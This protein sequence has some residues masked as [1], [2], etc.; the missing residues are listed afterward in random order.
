[1]LSTNSLELICI[2]RRFHPT[3]TEGTFFFQ[4][5]GKAQTVRTDK[6]ILSKKNKVGGN[7]LS[8]NKA[9]YIARVIKCIIDGGIDS[10]VNGIE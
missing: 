2:F 6:T 7:A 5:Y 10:L 3:A 1:M 4:S 8:D 9:Y